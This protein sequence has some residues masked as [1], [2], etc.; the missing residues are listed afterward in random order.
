MARASISP[1]WWPLVSPLFSDKT[2]EVRV[3]E[4]RDGELLLVAEYPNE[5]HAIDEVIERVRAQAAGI[6]GC[7]GSR[8]GHPYRRRLEGPTVIA[9]ERCRERLRAGERALDIADDYWRLDG[10]WRLTRVTPRASHKTPGVRSHTPRHPCTTM[11]PDELRQTIADFRRDISADIVGQDEAVGRLALLGAL[12]VGG[13]LSLGGRALIMGS[14]GVGKTALTQ[15]LRRSLEPYDV[16]WIAVDALDLTSPGW[17]GAPSIGDLLDAELGGGPIERLQ[18][19]VVVVDE[20]HH[21][22]VG[23][24]VVG[25]FLSK[26]REI[27]AS[28]LGLAGHGTVHLADGREWSSAHALV[29]GLGAFTGQLDLSRPPTPGAI[30]AAGLPLEL[31]TRMG[32]TILLRP[33]SEP[34]LV[35]LLRRWRPLVSLTDLCARLGYHVRIVDEAYARA[36]RVVVL[37]HDQSTARTAGTWLVSALRHALLTALADPDV[38]ELVVTP[39]DL[40]ITPDATREPPRDEPPEA[41]GGWDTTIILTPR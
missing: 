36:A 23:P 21:A 32:E 29:L 26:R 37:G 12:H 31:V 33:L 18:H 1:G 24:D 35:A 22:A 15:A 40:P 6:C 28:L 30:V 17:S 9:C 14:S 38:R 41:A 3:C 34:A 19:A 13:G 20:I 16:P 10:T 7:C 8:N 5:P 27:L 4:E 39:D 25:S 11:Q 2:L